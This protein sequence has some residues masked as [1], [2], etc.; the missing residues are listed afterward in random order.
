MTALS[1]NLLPIV[2][3]TAAIPIRKTTQSTLQVTPGKVGDSGI[4][5]FLKKANNIVF[6]LT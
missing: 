1:N 5:G 2:T 6:L 3:L 4:H